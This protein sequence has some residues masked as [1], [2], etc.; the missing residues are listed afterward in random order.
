MR[1]IEMEPRKR[2]RPVLMASLLPLALLGCADSGEPE[3]ASAES[4]S[5]AKVE[6]GWYSTNPYDQH[7]RMTFA[8]ASD[9]SGF[10][11]SWDCTRTDWITHFDYS[12]YLC[13][14][15]V[16]ADDTHANSEFFEGLWGAR[17]HSS[18]HHFL[19]D[20][21]EP[22]DSACAN[23]VADLYKGTMTAIAWRAAGYEDAFQ[24]AIGAVT[25]AI[26]DSFAPAHTTRDSAAANYRNLTELCTIGETVA[27]VCRHPEPLFPQSADDADDHNTERLL[28]IYATTDY[29]IAVA[30]VV[31]NRDVNA[32]ASML[33]NWFYCPV[34]TWIP[35]VTSS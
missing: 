1:H 2:M 8:A 7:G 26:Q 16:A 20:G 31:T 9:A 6:Q 10:G 34:L 28:S 29:L 25:H 30:L 21:S 27:G 35:S 12:G 4:E 23:S 19:R 3:A 17:A 5:V 11:V 24:Y 18:N 13:S 14:G 22:M 15:N 32:V 33:Q